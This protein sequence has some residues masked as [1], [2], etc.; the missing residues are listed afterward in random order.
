[1]FHGALARNMKG[2]PMLA[3]VISLLFGLVAFAALAQVWLSVGAGM[4]RARMLQAQLTCTPGTV[5]AKS[6]RRLDR[7]SW[8]PRLAAA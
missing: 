2:R 8:Q 7:P 4:R 3:V 1:M 6:A 5:R